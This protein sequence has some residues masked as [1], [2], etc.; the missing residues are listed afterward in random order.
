MLLSF[1]SF[2]ILSVVCGAAVASNNDRN[3]IDR[4]QLEAATLLRCSSLQT[5]S[6]QRV[7]SFSFMLLV[8][9]SVFCG[10]V[11]ASNND[12][13]VIDAAVTSGD[14]SELSLFRGR[15]DVDEVSLKLI[16][17]LGTIQTDCVSFDATLTFRHAS[18][19]TL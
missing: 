4:I 1:L 10:A 15:G 6:H 12:R 3:M 8:Y 18:Y 14:A 7:T 11:V 13:S 5:L 19:H 2:N 9:F 17:N 16:A